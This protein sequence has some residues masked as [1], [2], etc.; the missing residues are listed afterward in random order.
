M[1]T[2]RCKVGT[3]YSRTGLRGLS[4]IRGDLACSSKTRIRVWWVETSATNFGQGSNECLFTAR[5]DEIGKVGLELGRF[6]N[7]T[8]STRW[9]LVFWTDFYN[10]SG[11]AKYSKFPKLWMMKGQILHQLNDVPNARKFY[12]KGLE[13]CR[14]SIPLWLLLAR[15]EEEQGQFHSNLTFTWRFFAD[16][17]VERLWTPLYILY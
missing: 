14:D 4:A 7:G 16:A 1:A 13:N 5:Y 10:I 15:L 12:A 3:R 11:L 2:R 17:S 9:R 6:K 8:C